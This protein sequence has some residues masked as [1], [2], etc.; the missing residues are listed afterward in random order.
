LFVEFVTAF[1]S[2]VVRRAIFMA[3]SFMVSGQSAG[4]PLQARAD[5]DVHP[6]L[7]GVTLEI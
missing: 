5:P 4:S 3:K 2:F 7:K 6:I 1:K